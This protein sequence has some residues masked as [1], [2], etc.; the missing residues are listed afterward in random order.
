[1]AQLAEYDRKTTFH[2]TVKKTERMTPESYPDEVRHLV[3]VPDREDIRFEVG[4]SIGV[5]VPGPHEFGNKEHFRLYSIAGIGETQ[6][7]DGLTLA[8]CVRRCFYID[9]VNGERYPGVASNYLC[10]RQPGDRLALAG[11]FDSA[12][13]LPADPTANLI[14]V[15]LGTGIAPFR[16]FVSRMYGK[17]GGWKGQVRLFY[18]A[19]T[20]MELVYMNDR[21]NDLANYYDQATFKAF[22]AVSPKPY[23][24]APIELARTLEKNA[25]EIWQLLQ[26]PNTYVFVAGLEK[27]RDMMEGAMSNIAGSAQEWTAKKADLIARGRWAELIY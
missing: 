4:Q 16:A 24:D 7:G 19:K 15:G 21:R 22:E 12:F 26:D 20:G 6:E 27:V 1:M 17:L 13:K 18:G 10:D 2:A 5:V 25:Q 23:L 11:P 8:I 9:D 14:M 3:L